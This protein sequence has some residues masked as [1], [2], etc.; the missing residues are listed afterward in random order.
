[1]SADNYDEDGLM[2]LAIAVIEQAR[3]DYKS[4]TEQGCYTSAR[5]IADRDSR[6]LI[7]FIL[8]WLNLSKDT[9]FDMINSGEI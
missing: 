1:M 6:G 9:F 4:L 8:E 2:K 7:G 3:L 5:I